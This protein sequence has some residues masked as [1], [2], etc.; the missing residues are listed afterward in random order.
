MDLYDACKVVLRPLT[1]ALFAARASGEGHVPLSGPVVIAANHVSYLDPP[2]LGTWFPRP[3]HFMAKQEL[4]KIPVLGSLISA[5]HA[6]PVDRER[7]DVGAIRRALRILKAGR[8]VGIFP[9]GRRNVAGDAQARG[10]AVLLAATARCPLVPVA[11]ISTNLAIRRLRRSHVEVR[12]G[13]PISFQGSD[14]KP[15][16]T[17]LA[18]WTDQVAIAINDLKADRSEKP[19]R[20]S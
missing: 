10:G 2:M 18:Q 12:I 13:Q 7:G 6:F 1:R 16:K 4:F 5:V 11:L 9:E 8:V 17:E 20:E 3:V 15:T 19:E 14:R